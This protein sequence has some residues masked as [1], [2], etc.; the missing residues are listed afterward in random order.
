ML[1]KKLRVDNPTALLVAW[2]A[3]LPFHLGSLALS[4]ALGAPLHPLFGSPFFV[5]AAPGPKFCR[6]F[7]APVSSADQ[8]RLY[9]CLAQSL[10]AALGRCGTFDWGPLG[11][12]GPGALFL[13]RVEPYVA[14]VQVRPR[15]A[16]R[17]QGRP[18]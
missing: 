14:V 18:G 12:E 15:R 5:P 13:V 16:E 4:V 3:A 10:C 6:A 17:M 8:G 9:A 7:G 2:L 11:A 1:I